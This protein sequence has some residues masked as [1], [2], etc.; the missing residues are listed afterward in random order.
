VFKIAYQNLNY[1]DEYLGFSTL[2]L[3]NFAYLTFLLLIAL[4]FSR[5]TTAA[6]EKA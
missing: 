2:R 5:F 6:Q 3:R 1:E 4:V